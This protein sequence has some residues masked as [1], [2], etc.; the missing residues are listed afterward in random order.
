MHNYEQLRTSVT[1]NN[2]NQ[3]FS[4]DASVVLQVTNTEENEMQSAGV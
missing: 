2:L 3:S 1:A 4:D